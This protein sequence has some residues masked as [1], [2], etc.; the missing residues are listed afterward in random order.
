VTTGNQF[1]AVLRDD[2]TVA[3]WGENGFGQLADGTRGAQLAPVATTLE[4]VE[5]L[6]AGAQHACAIIAGEA[7]CWGDN[8]TGAI[9][10]GTL[11]TRPTPTRVL[12]NVQSISAGTGSTCAV[13]AGQAWCWGAITRVRDQVRYGSAGSS[14]SVAVGADHACALTSSGR[15]NCWGDNTYGQL[16]NGTYDSSFTRPVAAL[17]VTNAVQVVTGNFSTCAL[18]TDGTVLC[19]GILGS[20]SPF[21]S[22]RAVEIALDDV[23]QIDAG[24]VYSMC[25]VRRDNSLWCWGLLV[26]DGSSERRLTPVRVLEGVESVSVSINHTCAVLTTGGVRCWGNN[27]SGQ[28]GTGT[29]DESLVPTAVLAPR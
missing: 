15:V 24:D 13:Q 14:R 29:R 1:S 16:G 2:G 5:A 22:P 6:T 12:S 9:G 18:R 8:G 7:W 4:N 25:A 17:E 27:D 21:T 11:E 28:L 19:W 3:A 20:G 26:G 10:D 23:A